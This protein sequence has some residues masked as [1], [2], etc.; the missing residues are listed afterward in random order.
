MGYENYLKAVGK[1]VKNFIL[2]KKI[3]EKP[4]YVTKSPDIHT[5]KELGRFMDRKK[6]VENIELKKKLLQTESKLEEK[7]KQKER[8]LE[9]QD[10]MNKIRTQKEHMQ[11]LEKER[12]LKLHFVGLE[13][14]PTLFTKSNIPVGRIKGLYLKETKDGFL[15]FYP[16]LESKNKNT[17]RIL[18]EPVTGFK[19]FFKSEIGIVSQ[20]RGGKLD[21]NYEID[22]DGKLLYLPPKEFDTEKKYKVINLSESETREY[23]VREEQLRNLIREN[24]GKIK[25]MKN[26]EVEFE[27]QLADNEVLMS[28]AVKERDLYASNYALL[29]KKQEGMYQQ[30]LSAVSE[31]E[32][33]KVR[34]IL[35]ERL[36][37]AMES[38]L[39]TYRS[40]FEEAVSKELSDI[41]REK[42]MEMQK[43]SIKNVENMLDKVKEVVPSKRVVSV[44]KGV[45]E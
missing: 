1:S 39:E 38:A 14:P 32:D 42:F 15:L 4:L 29:I 31:I 41:E 28:S 3:I 21:S 23:E 5:L 9:E 20:M 2:R 45:E 16:L 25:D 34:A 8:I 43:D 12:A 13:T 6:S 22:E 33:V 26:R 18:N 7:D 44:G 17:T 24:Y 10:L 27:T 30:M 35:S 19:K 36:A 37:K 40:K 11:K